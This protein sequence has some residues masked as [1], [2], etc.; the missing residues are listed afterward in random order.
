MDARFPTRR[1]INVSINKLEPQHCHSH[2]ETNLN[3]SMATQVEVKFGGMTYSHVDSS[4]SRYVATFS[5]LIFLV[6]TEETGVVTLLDHNE[7]NTWLIS[8]F[9]FRTGFANGS[10]FMRKNLLNH[11]KTVFN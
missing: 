5:D 6:A 8:D 11:D 2:Q 3:S 9:Q 4:T 7:S 10:Q 1:L